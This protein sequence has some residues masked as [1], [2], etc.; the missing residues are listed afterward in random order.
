MNKVCIAS[1]VLFLLGV[2]AF[3]PHIQFSFSP[4]AALAQDGGGG[5]GDDGSEP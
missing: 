5:S 4:S 2:T 1:V 3:L